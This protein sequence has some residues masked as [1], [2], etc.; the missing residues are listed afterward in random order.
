MQADT[1]PAKVPPLR[2]TIDDLR[3]GQAL[4][5]KADLQ[6]TPIANG[7][8]VDR[9]RTQSKTVGLDAAGEW[10]RALKGS[11]SNFKVDFTAGSLGKMMDAFGFVGMVQGGKT[12]ATLVGSWPGSPGAFALANL[13]GTL[14]VDVGEG[15]LL[16]VEPGGSGRYL[17]RGPKRRRGHGAAE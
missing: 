15:R 10:V 8:R 6:T 4:L 16:D 5:G 2:F 7:M 11:R 12:R 14:K 13:G 1:D 17:C 3:M 9:F